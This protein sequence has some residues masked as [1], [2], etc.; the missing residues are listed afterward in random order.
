[1]GPLPRRRC[2]PEITP[3]NVATHFFEMESTPEVEAVQR[4]LSLAPEDA[5]AMW[6]RWRPIRLK[7][8]DNL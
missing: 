1:M 8:G 3:E 4:D 6:S 5:A 7:I 2:H